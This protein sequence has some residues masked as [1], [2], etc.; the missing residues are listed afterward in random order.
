MTRERKWENRRHRSWTP[1][2]VRSATG[3][4]KAAGNAAH[5]QGDEC[6]EG[7]G[8]P[9]R[10]PSSIS[11]RCRGHRLRIAKKKG[12]FPKHPA[13]DASPL[14]RRSIRSMTWGSATGRRHPDKT[15]G[16]VSNPRKRQDSLAATGRS[17]YLG[18][19]VP[20]A[21]T[22]LLQPEA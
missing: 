14:H 10:P 1:A 5:Q 2:M 15:M 16:V 7:A 21:T 6:I 4:K 22:A 12:V 18:S 9:A 20:T 17:A 11:L 8:V 19:L 13:F 3:K